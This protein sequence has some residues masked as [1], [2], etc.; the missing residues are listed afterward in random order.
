MARFFPDRL[1]PGAKGPVPP[2]LFPV[3]LAVVLR[4]WNLDSQSVWYDD[5]NCAGYLGCERFADYLAII[6]QQNPEAVPLYYVLVYGWTRLVGS[7]GIVARW[8]SVAIHGVAAWALF[9]AGMAL[10]GRRAGLLA[11]LWFACSPWQVWHGQ[12]IRPYP[13]VTLLTCLVLWGL[14]TRIRSGHRG[15]VSGIC[16]VVALVILPWTHLTTLVTLPALVMGWVA[17]TGLPDRFRIREAAIVAAVATVC[18]IPLAYWVLHLPMVSA[19]AYSMYHPPDALR[20][21]FAVLA[22]DAPQ[23]MGEVLAGFPERW[24]PWLPQMVFIRDSLEWLLAA[25]GCAAILFTGIRI[26]RKTTRHGAP[27]ACA[28]LRLVWIMAVLPPVLLILLSYFW[29]PCFMPRYLSAS[30]PALYLLIGVTL[31]AVPRRWFPAAILLPVVPLALTWI[32]CLASVSR[33]DWIKVASVLRQETQSNDL[34]L[35]PTLLTSVPLLEYHLAERHRLPAG[36]NQEIFAVHREKRTSYGPGWIYQ[37]ELSGRKIGFGQMLTPLQAVEM[38][39]EYWKTHPGA[40]IWMVWPVEPYGPQIFVPFGVCLRGCFSNVMAHIFPGQFPLYLACV[41]YPKDVIEPS[42]SCDSCV[43]KEDVLRK[44]WQQATGKNGEIMTE[45]AVNALQRSMPENLP[46][47]PVSILGESLML[48]AM[49]YFDLSKVL[50]ESTDP[51][52][53]PDFPAVSLVKAIYL[54]L[55]GDDCE[56]VE[57][58][59]EEVAEKSRFFGLYRPAILA[60]CRG[61]MEAFAR[62]TA[63]LERI[64]I[65]WMF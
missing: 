18:W 37:A 30:V 26:C 44:F 22:P 41:Q 24:N 62:E 36:S 49:G 20:S 51:A 6:R 56:T 14:I 17:A 50:V 46:A 45:M 8:F 57:S 1:K 10:A 29:R 32:T 54:A 61:D 4:A 55:S 27:E 16:V 3:A 39:R 34:I 64:G 52:N 11:A 19:L 59:L 47:D 13:L 28:A 53:F 40:R 65:P 9:R 38:A 42:D 60:R 35:A 25:T 23:R 12:S 33:T 15:A 2:W 43:I 7:A 63:R 21:L 48:S 5:Y 31:A 58:L